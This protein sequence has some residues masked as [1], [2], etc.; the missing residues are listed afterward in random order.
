[1]PNGVSVISAPVPKL[2]LVSVVALV[3]AGATRDPVQKDGLASLTAKLLL[4]GTTRLD[5]AALIDAFERLGASVEAGAGWDTA[6]VQLTALRSNVQ[7]SM[8]LLRDVVRQP[9]FPEREVTRL[10]AERQAERLQVR[11]EPREL[12]DESF[13]RFLYAAQSR[14]ALPEGGRTASIGEITRDDVAGFYAG[15]YVPERL[16][17][18]VAGDMTEAE[19]LA[20]VTRAFGDWTGTP[21][22]TPAI[23]DRVRSPKRRVQVV[24][25]DD[26]PQSELRIG[27]R[28]VPRGH[29]DYFKLVL[30]NA[31]LG[32]LFSSRINLN[33]RERHGYAYGAHS[34][35][36]W[37]RNSG[38]FVVST[39]VESGVTADATREVLHEID[40][41]RAE[42]IS[43]DEL[44]LATSYLAGVFPIRYETTAAIANALT[45]LAAYG[46]PDDYFDTYRDR[47]TSVTAAD[48][49]QMA[50][51]HLHPDELLVLA[52]G[53]P[54]VVVDPLGKLGVGPVS[55]ASADDVEQ[56]L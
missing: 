27:H 2:P 5:G 34:N 30:M 33:L 18:I 1:L 16:T 56:G 31:V 51:T 53:D 22:E 41:M 37:R 39:A 9:V 54:E 48:V 17:V 20:L 47:I 13:E 4:E 15:M 45:A 28:G 46:Y 38:P 19:S 52:V 7:A 42:E 44:S 10:K 32:G 14:Y 43:T 8:D 36:E 55:V 26:A 6:V 50:K 3:D 49:L 25:K 23:D 24:A 40:R 29:P 11:T 12:A 21:A 35:F